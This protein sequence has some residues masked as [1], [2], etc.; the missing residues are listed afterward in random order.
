MT[1]DPTTLTSTELAA[2]IEDYFNPPEGDLQPL[3]DAKGKQTAAK[4]EPVTFSGLASHLGFESRDAF[5]DYEQNGMFAGMLKRA[6][7]RID[8]ACE[9]KLHQSPA[10]LIF[11]LKNSGWG[12]KSKDQTTDETIPKTLTVKLIEAGP[13]PASTEKDVDAG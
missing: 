4:E 7:L 10:G 3:E 1:P 13:E 11:L 2:L 5:A 6:R 8:E 12:E 9:K